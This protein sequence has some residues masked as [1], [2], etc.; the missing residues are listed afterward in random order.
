[1]PAK[2]GS[3]LGP[4]ASIIFFAAALT[5]C[6]TAPPAPRGDWSRQAEH[7]AQLNN[8]QFRGRVNVRY[9]NESHTPRILWRQ[10]ERHYNIRLWGTFNAGNTLISGDPTGV[11][12]E[13]NGEVARAA[14]PED[15]VLEQLG[16]EL[17]V[18]HL[19]FWIRGLP[20]PETDAEM[21]FDDFGQLIAIRQQGWNVRYS[22]PRQYG[23]VILPGEIEMLRAGGDVR[24]RFV[25]LRWTIDGQAE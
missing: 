10:Q 17:P 9:D 6:A 16:Y 24:L 1:M 18:S 14:T 21:D 19:E 11:V 8:W 5:A 7:L 15:L 2:T 25:G 22:N 12:F 4:R 3:R 23:E 13:T 20:A